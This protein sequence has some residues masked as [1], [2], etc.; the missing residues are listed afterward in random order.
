MRAWVV[1]AVALLAVPAAAR[2]GD[3]NRLTYLDGSDPYYVGRDFPRLVTPQWVGDEG[4]EAAIILA[5]DDM[6]GHEKWE[7][8][9]RPILER[10]KRIDGRAPVS[11]M[12]C[13]I[14]P[15][16]PHLQK[17]LKEGLSLETHTLD[18][19]CP[20]FQKGDLGRA[21]DTFEKC[22]DLLAE[23]PG[24]RPVAFRTPCCDSQ[25][26]VSPRFYS[27]MFNKSTPKGNFLTA[28]SS[29]FNVFTPADPGLPRE[30]VLEPDGS[31][32]FRKYLP[33]SGTFGNFIEDYP[34]PYVVGRL[35]WEFPCVTPSD[36]QAKNLYG[37]GN[38]LL[39]RDWKA[40]LDAVVRKQGTFT[41]VFHPYGWSTPEQVI[42]LIDHAVGRYGKKVKFLTFR[43]AQE[44]LD[45]HLLGG[46]PL[47]GARGQDNGVRLLDVDNDGCLDVVIGNEKVRQTRVW[48]PRTHSWSVGAFPAALVRGGDHSE[49][50]ARFGVVRPDGRASLIVRNED[51]SGGWYFDGGRWVEDRTLLAGLEVEGRP[52][53][54]AREGR[55]RGVR[56]RDLDG[57]GRCECIAGNDSQPAVFAW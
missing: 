24:S 27:E 22:V 29:V 23:V 50:G 3:G 8:F 17:W 36:W 38:P 30:L 40:A 49:A 7:A 37:P 20:L 51:F 53:F 48:S 54:T 13:K 25:N 21:R 5:I 12:T 16:E 56:L 43:E 55:D 31:E 57:D 47:R 46:Q 6:R 45:K 44:R 32:R 41:L 2:A 28:D 10:L 11:I 9:L 42:D 39:L 33:R 18:H 1:L 14:D 52:V 35:C 15:K 26:T 34:Y 4:V 19:P